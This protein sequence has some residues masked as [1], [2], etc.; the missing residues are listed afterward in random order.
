MAGSREPR[1]D[2][3]EIHCMEMIEVVVPVE[4][5]EADDDEPDG[6]NKKNPGIFFNEDDIVSKYR[7]PLPGQGTKR[8]WSV[9]NWFRLTAWIAFWID[10]YWALDA[11]RMANSPFDSTPDADSLLPWPPAYNASESKIDEID[12]D[13]SVSYSSSAV[14]FLDMLINGILIELN[15][16]LKLGPEKDVY[17]TIEL[18]EAWPSTP[19]TRKTRVVFK[20]ALIGWSISE[21]VVAITN[22]LYSIHVYKRFKLS[23]FL[24][25]LRLLF[26]PAML[27]RYCQ[28]LNYERA[29]LDE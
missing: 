7:W 17:D 22:I 27:F 25:L 15:G 26:I 13:T 9:H 16:R 1:E 2:V 28:I 24:F 4:S 23:L 3:D 12:R 5:K 11:L 18:L 10:F 8:W 20:R 21:T 14:F 29:L 6:S 19:S